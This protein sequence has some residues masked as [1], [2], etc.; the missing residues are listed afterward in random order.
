MEKFELVC[1]TTSQSVKLSEITPGPIT[2]GDIFTN[3]RRR[4]AIDTFEKTCLKI[5]KAKTS[6]NPYY[7]LMFIF[8]SVANGGVARTLA[9]FK[10]K[11]LTYKAKSIAIDSILDASNP[12]WSIRKEDF[13]SIMRLSGL[14]PTNAL[15]SKDPS[16]QVP[17]P[18]SK[19]E[20]RKT[21]D[22][23]STIYWLHLKE[24]AGPNQLIWVKATDESTSE[25]TRVSF[26]GDS[27]S[28]PI[29]ADWD[30]VSIGISNGTFISGRPNPDLYNEIQV[31]KPED[32]TQEIQGVL[33]KMLQE[34]IQTK[35]ALPVT[36]NTTVRHGPES[37]YCGNNIID[38][39]YF[40][41]T[42]LNLKTFANY[43]SEFFE[44][45]DTKVYKVDDWQMLQYWFQSSDW[46]YY[47]FDKFSGNSVHLTEEEKDEQID[48]LNKKLSDKIK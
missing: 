31:V 10:S 29:I 26:C 18:A 30:L 43:Y 12:N 11:P 13:D 25:T 35:I 23:D 33:P 21:S 20:Y 32:S 7:G 36:A 38:D 24:T 9:G 28:N 42:N 2:Y 48:A 14:L 17:T 41:V 16:K 8:R 37:L 6:L 46:F 39:E 44:N 3:E 27:V 19:F 4:D 5:K 22:V 1:T 47:N 15:L 45:S 34:V 40:V